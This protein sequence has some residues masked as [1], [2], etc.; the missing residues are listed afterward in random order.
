[1]INNTTFEVQDF[2]ADLR[3]IE[4]DVQVSEMRRQALALSAPTGGS[5]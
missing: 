1:M 5:Q 2:I 3:L 4:K